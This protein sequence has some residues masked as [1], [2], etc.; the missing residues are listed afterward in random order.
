MPLENLN[1]GVIMIN[2]SFFPLIGNLPKRRSM[3][4]QLRKAEKPGYK[5]NL[6]LIMF[7]EKFIGS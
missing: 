6:K 2:M 7:K 1:V 5:G 3:V 4:Q